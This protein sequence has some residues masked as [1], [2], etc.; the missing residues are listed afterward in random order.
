MGHP[1]T[2]FAFLGEAEI[3]TAGD[4][5]AQA[6]DLRDV[7]SNSGL[8]VAMWANDVRLACESIG[9]P[10]IGGVMG[11]G[12]DSPIKRARRVAAHAERAAESLRACSMS[13][14]KLPQAYL[15]AYSDLINDRRRA[16]RP[17]FD[18]MAG[19]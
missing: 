2:D 5:F 1:D 7:A 19:L 9:V 4:M 17:R 8:I 11:V 12:G 6:N 14:A 10:T 15:R 16:A 3:K 13:A 18:P